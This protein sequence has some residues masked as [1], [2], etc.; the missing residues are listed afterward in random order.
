MSQQLSKVQR[1]GQVTIPVEIREKWQL[2]EGD[3]I[4]FSETTHGVIISPQVTVP[5]N[6]LNQ[7]APNGPD[8]ISFLQGVQINTA[9]VQ[10][11]G[12]TSVVRKTF[13]I[14]Q[15]DQ[16]GL[17]NFKS[18]RTDFIEHLGAERL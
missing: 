5:V 15:S 13:G 1:K 10:K 12:Q 6:A 9:T 11:R 18:H 8:I 4:A 3:L 7:T 2:K 14:F 17:A 16:K